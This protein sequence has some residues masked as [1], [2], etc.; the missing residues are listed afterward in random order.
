MFA[1]YLGSLSVIVL[2]TPIHSHAAIWT[3]WGA[4][5]DYSAALRT[6]VLECFTADA[7]KLLAYSIL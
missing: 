2:C 1:D 4:G 6:V 5:S 7:A 3:G